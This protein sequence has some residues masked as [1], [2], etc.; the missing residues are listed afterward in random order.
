MTAGVFDMSV[1]TIGY[2]L[3][4]LIG[5]G[6]VFSVAEVRGQWRCG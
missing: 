1:T 2:A 4:G 6:I 3:A 5:V